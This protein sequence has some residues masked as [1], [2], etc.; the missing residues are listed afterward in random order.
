MSM[1][2]LKEKALVQV[3]GRYQDTIAEQKA[4]ITRL[5]E[6]I[7]LAR[8]ALK[9]FAELAE[10]LEREFSDHDDSVIA[11][12]RKAVYTFGDLRRA[13]SF[14]TSLEVKNNG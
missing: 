2:E 4:E 8:E 12:G 3:V 6:Q 9:P 14:L 1:D 11:G 5:R 7:S 13:R 10:D